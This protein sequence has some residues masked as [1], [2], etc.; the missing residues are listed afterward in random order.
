MTIMS[1]PDGCEVPNPPTINYFSNPDI[2][3][4]GEPTGTLTDDN[5]RCIEESMV[6][7]LF[8]SVWLPPTPYGIWRRADGPLDS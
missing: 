2:D 1:Y 6:I 8:A 4:L 5:A 3:Y 7:L